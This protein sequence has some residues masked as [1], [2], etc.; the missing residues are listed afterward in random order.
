MQ[1]ILIALVRGYRYVISPLLGN[2]CRFYPSC[3]TYAET[4]LA[5]HGATHGAWLTVKRLA[6]CHPWCAGGHDPVPPASVTSAPG[7]EVRHG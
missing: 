4:A 1:K 2:H 5:T 7:A 6:R 3:S